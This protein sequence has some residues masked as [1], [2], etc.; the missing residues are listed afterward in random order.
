MN[1]SPC[2]RL[3]AAAL[4]LAAAPALAF[5]QVGAGDA[6]DPA[7]P[8]PATRYQPVHEHRPPATPD[9]WA[10]TPDRNWQAGNRA[11]TA[12]DADADP[13]AGHG[14]HAHHQPA[15]QDKPAADPHAHQHGHHQR[16]HGD[17]GGHADHGDHGKKDQH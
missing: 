3:A 9:T 2:A 16:H 13:H 11:V 4:L 17:H 14:A 5:A 1:Q 8:V 10:A 12:T 6:G 15:G 7:A